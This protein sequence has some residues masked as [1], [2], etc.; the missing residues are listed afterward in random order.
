MQGTMD[1]Q[2]A[3]D[4]ATGPKTDV[5]RQSVA[6]GGWYAL[7]L[8][9]ATQ[10]M[11]LLDRNILAILNPRIKADL[12]IGDAEMGLLYGTVFALFY[13]LFSLPL[14]RLADGWLRGRLLAICIVFWSVA[15]GLAAFATGF[16][17]LALSRLGVGIGEAASQPAGT[18]LVYDYFPKA[19]RGFVMAI[20]G[21]G[22]A[23]GL[24]LSSILGGMSADWWDMR[25]AT[26]GAPLGL[27]GWQFA[28]LVAASPGF[29][30][31]VLLW[32]LREPK[33]GEIDRI[34][35][36]ADPAPFSASAAV[37]GAILPG[38][39]WVFLRRH[40]A[41]GRTMWLN[42]AGL[43][44]IVASMALLVRW[45]GYVSPRPPLVIGGVHLDPHM[46]Q[47]SVVGFGL[48]VL[49]NLVQSLRFSDP[50]AFAVMMRS[51]SLILCMMVASLQSLIN[52]GVMGFT[53]AFL[54]KTYGLSPSAT[55]LQFGVLTAALGVIGPLIAG[56]LSDRLNGILPGTGRVW[57]T[58]FALALS[59]VMAFWV[60][61]SPDPSAFYLRFSAY[62]LILTMWLPPIY[63]V[64]FDQVLP[65]MRAITAST[66]IFMMTILGLGIGPYFVGMVSDARG[67][68]LAGAILTVNGVA[69]VILVLLL[70]LAARVRRDE[71]HML[72]RARS[73]GE[74]I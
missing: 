49:L 31:S 28:F 22:I 16:A 70:I 46:L 64:M 42:L 40:Q 43:A 25:F 72:D 8:I 6:A 29:I 62:S 58:L 30:L 11:S 37:L 73:A 38:S 14:G 3:D 51:P 55:G 48:F 67:G 39:N 52:Y 69:P 13:A 71:K 23:V 12:H 9:F 1:A 65:R 24:G 63:A 45:C 59:P 54:M 27:K 2:R 32:R 36:P 44:L 18:S 60:Y 15:T 17:M 33:R 47:W 56:P 10:M 20:L 66:C 57:V 68:D 53:P 19:R 34:H 61:R 7:A 21:A 5:A 35:T 50:A 74:P 4:R 26:G 41:G